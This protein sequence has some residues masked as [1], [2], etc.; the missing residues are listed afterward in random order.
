MGDRIPQVESVRKEGI[1]KRGPRLWQADARDRRAVVRGQRSEGR[2]REDLCPDLCRDLRLF[3]EDKDYD[4]DYDKERRTPAVMA[5]LT[6][7]R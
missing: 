5:N 4:K 7:G 1:H 2:G 6:G 3:S